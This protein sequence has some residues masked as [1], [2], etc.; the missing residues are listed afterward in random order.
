VSSAPDFGQMAFLAA[1]DHEIALIGINAKTT[2]RLTSVLAR[3]P[4]A[5][6]SSITMGSTSPLISK[7]ITVTFSNGDQW[8]LEVS[9]AMKR[10]AK[11]VVD[12]FAAI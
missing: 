6:V 12:A 10:N 7:P 11:K 8:L 9:A 5:D 1:T 3:V 4:R 2:A